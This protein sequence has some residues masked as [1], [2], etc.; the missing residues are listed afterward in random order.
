MEQD[1]FFEGAVLQLAHT[2]RT[3]LEFA[4]TKLT[5]L[6]GMQERGSTS[7]GFLVFVAAGRAAQVSVSDLPSPEPRTT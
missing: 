2:D 3:D 7:L 1:L 6:T 4:G 5:M